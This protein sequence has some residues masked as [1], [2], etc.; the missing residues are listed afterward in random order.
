MKKRILFMIVVLLSAI[1]TTFAK[2]HSK[3]YQ[4][5]LK[6]Y[7]VDIVARDAIGGEDFWNFTWRQ[8]ERFYVCR[9]ERNWTSEIYVGAS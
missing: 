2:D 4:K 8:N 1:S 5:L 7:D 6:K 3:E 9:K